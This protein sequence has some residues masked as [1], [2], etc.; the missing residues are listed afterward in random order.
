M[1]VLTSLQAVKLRPAT[2]R[3]PVRRDERIAA[4]STKPSGPASAL[5]AGVARNAIT[6]G[7][8][9]LPLVPR[10]RARVSLP[11]S[12]TGSV[13]LTDPRS[14]QTLGFHLRGSRAVGGAFV[15]GYVVYPAGAV[16]G[17]DM[18]H[19]V[20]REG[21]EDYVA[22]SKRPEHEALTYDLELPAATRGLRLVD[23]VLEVLDANGT[24][25]F[26]VG[27]PFVIDAQGRRVAASLDV[28]GCDVDR[29]AMPSFSTPR[30]P[31]AT[32]ACSVTIGWSGVTYPAIVDPYWSTTRSMTTA[33]GLFP[34]VMLGDGRILVAGGEAP[35]ALL[36]NWTYLGASEIYDPS[37]DTWSV[38][39]PLNVTR[40]AHSM[41]TR[42]DGSVLA[43]GGYNDLVYNDTTET[44]NT[45]TGLWTLNVARLNA[46]R[47]EHAA[48]DLANG[49][50][51]VSGGAGLD[52]NGD[53]AVIASAEIYDQALG[54]WRTIPPMR[55]ARSS[56]FL[57]RLPSGALFTA[58]GAW[59]ADAQFSESFDETTEQWTDAG[60]LSVPRYAMTQTGLGDGRILIA[61]GSSGVGQTL[62]SADIYDSAT[63]SYT[64]VPLAQARANHS[65][66]GMLGGRVLLAGGYDGANFTASTET[67]DLTTNISSLQARGMQVPRSI[68]SAIG[69]FGSG[70]VF[71]MGGVNTT[72]GALSDTEFGYPDDI[73]L[74]SG[75]STVETA[76]Q[77]LG[78]NV[79]SLLD[80]PLLTTNVTLTTVNTC[81]GAAAQQI[82]STLTATQDPPINYSNYNSDF[83]AY[84]SGGDGTAGSDEMSTA[85]SVVDDFFMWPAVDGNF[86][87]TGNANV[88]LHARGLRVGYTSLSIAPEV[89]LPDNSVAPLGDPVTISLD[90]SVQLVPIEVAVLYSDNNPLTSSR[91]EQQ[92]AFWDQVQQAANVSLL[93]NDGCGGELEEISRLVPDW[94]HRDTSPPPYGGLYLSQRSDTPDSIWGPL[95]NNRCRV[96]FRLVSY[97]EIHTDDLHA[98]PAGHPQEISADQACRENRAAVLADPRHITNPSVYVPLVI[99]VH[100]LTDPDPGGEGGE[101]IPGT[102]DPP[103]ACVPE[104]STAV[105][106][107]G[108]TTIYAHE[109]G[110]VLGL[111]DN[112]CP[113]PTY[114]MMCSDR[115]G[116]PPPFDSECDGVNA[117]AAQYAPFWSH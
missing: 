65:A 77:P 5:P 116:N 63:S 86:S 33:R 57:S 36:Q 35:D 100:E 80:N 58:G 1:E 84:G 70:G 74:V 39:G 75:Q 17:G 2:H 37:T 97:L 64:S 3:H 54:A 14:S 12:A 41:H 106:V 45:T 93:G 72:A 55:A 28:E 60:S 76:D 43:V 6:T 31:L 50:I 101:K 89:T 82:A 61:G 42:P 113:P 115:G 27:R 51:L 91:L 56:H 103:T 111:P 114:G 79:L 78:T 40:A 85:G 52:A 81:A 48:H 29:A 59:T 23:R 10:A 96:Q 15:R 19:R 83:L 21:T 95:S 90:P 88:D 94:P 18:L 38:T 7:S 25:L 62:A 117:A 49:N 20:T 9:I 67:F 44:F 69:G 112:G 46:G 26:R 104:F 8:T 110:H 13:H 68:H 47:G 66:T 107:Y 30:V 73:T 99:F 105:S 87:A 71:V 24:A 32:R 98:N 102:T 34:V 16:E 109:L 53:D 92:L 11:V 22:F 108:T 4:E